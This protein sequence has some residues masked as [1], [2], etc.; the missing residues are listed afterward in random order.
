MDASGGLRVLGKSDYVV[1]LLVDV[2][3]ID[4]IGCLFD[5]V[6]VGCF[7][8]LPIYLSAHPFLSGRRGWFRQTGG[9]RRESG[10]GNKPQD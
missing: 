3:F 8:Y 2:L 9:G 4:M 6:I 1:G 10:R 5:W 7:F